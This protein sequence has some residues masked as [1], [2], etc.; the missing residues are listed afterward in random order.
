[1]RTAQRKFAD[2][3]WA[4]WINGDDTSTI[5][6]TDWV[7][8]KGASYVDLAVHIR[9]ISVSTGLNIYVPFR[10]TPD[11]IDDV[12]LHFQDEHV[13]R[14]TFN[15]SCIID[16]KKNAC[17]SEI[18][19][20]GRTMDIVHISCVGFQVTPLAEGSLIYIDLL[21]LAPYLDNDEAYLMFRI[22]HKSLDEIFHNVVDMRNILTR[23]RDLI[24]SPVISEKYGY[25]VRINEARLLPSEISRS[26]AFH[27]QKLKK[28]A[29]TMSISEE[30]K[31]N[32]SNCYRIRRLEEELYREFAPQLFD[33]TNAITYQWNQTREFNL[34][35]HFNFYFD[36]ARDSISSASMLFYMI[37][38]LIVGSASS[39]LWEFVKYLFALL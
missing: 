16:F 13:L 23:I 28:A 38:L 8:P 10:I 29:V 14:A 39:A 2:D 15:A 26:G 35:G 36:I 30:Y 12:S 11:E 20:N 4:I 19:Y 3:G 6:L 27:I 34:N 18:A 25:S 37:L 17:T 21:E 31:I 1:M 24:T 22:P 9:G 5:Y 7:N 32:D 33:R